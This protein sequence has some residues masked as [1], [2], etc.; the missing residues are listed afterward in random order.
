MEKFVLIDTETFGLNEETDPILEV[1][2]KVYDLDFNELGN[3]ERLIWMEHYKARYLKEQAEKTF[4][5]D[6]HAK[7][8]LWDDIFNIPDSLDISPLTVERQAIEWL[9][10][11]GVTKDDPM[12]G[13]SVQFDRLM[14]RSQ[15]PGIESM[16]SYRNIDISTLKELCRRLNP[17][18]YKHLDTVPAKKNHRVLDDIDDTVDELKF[19]IE[20]FLF[21]ADERF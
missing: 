20:N 13:S 1:G 11:A 21:E 12:V 7:S 17:N 5:Y 2:F 3:F 6:M 4:V 9:K 15:M 16:F 14:F 10:K 19:Y 8:G 18:V